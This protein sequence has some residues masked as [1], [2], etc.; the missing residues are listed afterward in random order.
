MNKELF[1]RA[2]KSIDSGKSSQEVQSDLTSQGFIEDE[3]AEVIQQIKGAEVSDEDKKNMR[4]FTFKEIFDRIGYGFASTQFINILFYLIGAGFFVIGA[5][6]GLKT[7]ISI[8]ISSVMQEYA[9]S[10]KVSI[11]FLSKSGVLFGLSFLF[12]AMA[13]TIKSVPLFSLALLVGAVGVV[14]YGDLYER[15]AEEHLKK[16]KLGRFLRNISHFGVIITGVCMIISGMLFDMFPMLSSN[17]VTIFGRTFAL[18]GFL[19][20]FEITA[21]AFILSGYVLHFIKEKKNYETPQEGFLTEYFA[22]LTQQ[23][24]A[25]FSSSHLVLL[26]LASAITG[27]IQV[28]GN[29]YYGIFI[30]HKFTE[31]A[32]SGLLPGVFLNIAFMF[33]FAI[34]ASFLGPTFSEYLNKRVGLAPSLVFGALLVAMMP[35]VCVYNPNFMPLLVANGLGVM[36]SAIIGM[37]QGLLVR[38]LLRE[39]QRSLYYS[40]MGVG[41]AIPFLILVPIG[42]WIAHVYGLLVLFKILAGIMLVGAAPIYFILVIVASKQR[43]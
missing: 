15:L 29:S 27:L 5:I 16:E 2:K 1:Q 13:I 7:V 41:I 19:I 20:C 6:N 14:T 34:V 36:G 31:G 18:F 24:R 37:G 38:K 32:F 3:V 25:F 11:N 22:K 30:Y 4:I 26:L 17:Q 28:L 42:A 21:I 10:R 8:V 43:L 39:D 33:L 23:S 12:I 9:R 35:L 40:I